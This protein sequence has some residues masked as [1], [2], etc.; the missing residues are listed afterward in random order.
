MHM[1]NVGK[2]LELWI[3]K[4]SRTTAPDMRPT[5]AAFSPGSILQA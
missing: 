1:E 5:A 3:W 2:G 4:V